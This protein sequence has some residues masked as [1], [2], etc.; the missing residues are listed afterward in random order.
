MNYLKAFTFVEII[1]SITIISLISV[2]WIFYFN[3]FIGKQEIWIHI[4]SFKSTIN[5]LDYKIKKQDIFDYNIF[6]NKN[7]YWYTISENNIW[8]DYV[9]NIEFDTL[10]NSGSISINPADGEIW[11][12]KIY[13]NNKK[14]EQVTRNWTDTINI[15]IDKETR[16]QSS[17]S[18][19][20]LNT[21]TLKY[22]N[23]QDW[24]QS[25]ELYILDILDSTWTNSYDSLHI[26]NING[27]KS[28]YDNLLQINN[29][30]IIILFEQNWI[31]DKLELN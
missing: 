26:R 2:S 20:T 10:N 3:D 15:N 8:T 17:L 23:E 29:L 22:Y 9:Q 5:N 27:K 24:N 12:L 7:S 18:W 13:S 31:E 21:L 28:Y 19:S 11:E 30:P 6:I 4:Q 25:K 14:S 1:V 16:I